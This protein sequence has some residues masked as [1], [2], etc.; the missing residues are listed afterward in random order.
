GFPA[1]A[2]LRRPGDRLTDGRGVNPWWNPA[3]EGPGLRP[4]APDWPD[5]I[6]LRLQVSCGRYLRT[7]DRGT[8][9][10]AT[11]PNGERLEFGWRRPASGS[12]GCRCRAGLRVH[13][14]QGRHFWRLTWN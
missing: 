3:A 5:P 13:W 2:R 9:C 1:Q 11:P 7:P 14:L 10:S 4:G 6:R 8:S 12:L